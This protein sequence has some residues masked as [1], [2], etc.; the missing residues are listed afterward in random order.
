MR[1]HFWRDWKHL[2]GRNSCEADGGADT[3]ARTPH[4]QGLNDKALRALQHLGNLKFLYEAVLNVLWC[5]LSLL[6]RQPVSWGL[7]REGRGKSKEGLCR[8]TPL[9]PALSCALFHFSSHFTLSQCDLSH[10]WKNSIEGLRQ[11]IP[12]CSGENR[13]TTTSIIRTVL[14]KKKKKNWSPFQK[15][16]QSTPPD[17]NSV[18][19]QSIL[20]SLLFQMY[21]AYF[22][23]FTAKTTFSSLTHGSD[24]MCTTSTQALQVTWKI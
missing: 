2:S 16:A 15:N 17:P 21:S 3:C 11:M 23:K 4:R 9:W 6:A 12:M 22:G 1:G 10:G 8:R 13:K 24:K 20:V 7:W 5:S 18:I 14:E 19:L